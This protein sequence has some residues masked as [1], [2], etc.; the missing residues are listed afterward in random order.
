MWKILVA[1]LLIDLLLIIPSMLSYSL[2]GN[3]IPRSRAPK[4]PLK[5]GG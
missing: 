3:Y 2:V 4:T 1:A 5:M